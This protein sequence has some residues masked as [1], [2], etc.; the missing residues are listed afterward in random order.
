MKRTISYT[1][2]KENTGIKISTFLR[3]KGFSRQCLIELKKNEDSVFLNGVP[4]HFDTLLSHGDELKVFIREK[5]AAIIKA[6]DLPVNIIYEDEDLLVVNKAAGMPVHPSFHNEDNSLANALAW[7]YRAQA[8]DF[9][10]RCSNRLDR[11]TSGLTIVSKHYVSAAMISQMGARREISR[12]YLAIAAGQVTP[13]EGTI[14]APLARKD[15]SLIERFVD[16]QHGERAVTHYRVLSHFPPGT[17]G[18]KEGY[19]LLRVRLETGRTHQIRVHMQYLGHPLLGDPLYGDITAG[20]D[21]AL[22]SRQALH[23]YRLS[24]THPITGAALEFEAPLPE[25]MLRL[26]SATCN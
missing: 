7:H 5:P 20:E 11:D 22:I 13:E 14:D 17:A 18:I 25:D 6:S 2:S 21:A 10:F 23:A 3:R 4:K 16:P 1:I 26:V 24:F 15:T 9:A 19:T 8:K 12:E